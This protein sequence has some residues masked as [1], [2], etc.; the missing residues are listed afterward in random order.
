MLYSKAW[1]ESFDM[2]IYSNMHGL[3]SKLQPTFSPSRERLSPWLPQARAWC[4]LIICACADARHCPNQSLPLTAQP[5]APQLPALLFWAWFCFCS[6]DSPG[7]PHVDLTYFVR[8]NKLVSIS[9][10]I[11]VSWCRS[12]SRNDKSGCWCETGFHEI[13][14][15]KL[16]ESIATHKF[17]MS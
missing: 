9:W 11:V 13:L 5:A 8:W 15:V 4:A 12:W 10:Q 17:C 16:Q 6:H 3:S 1:N 14:F 2:K 7:C